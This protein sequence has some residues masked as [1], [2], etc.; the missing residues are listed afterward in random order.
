M[1]HISNKHHTLESDSLLHSVMHHILREP[2]PSFCYAVSEGKTYLLHYFENCVSLYSKQWQRQFVFILKLQKV[3]W[4]AFMYYKH[5]NNIT[6]PNCRSL[7]A[8]HRY[9]TKKKYWNPTLFHPFILGT[10]QVQEKMLVR[11]L[12]FS[13]SLFTVYKLIFSVLDNVS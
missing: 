11:I 8:E 2:V 12:F 13:F 10:Q 4:W 9:A 7:W 5:K 6:K 3:K 1:V